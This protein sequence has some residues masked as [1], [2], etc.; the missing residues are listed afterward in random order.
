MRHALKVTV[1]ALLLA[2]VV[3]LASVQVDQAS[4][5]GPR[6]DRTDGAQL[7]DF[8]QGNVDR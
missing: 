5:H 8:P 6:P 2:A 1:L 4:A 3:S 7:R